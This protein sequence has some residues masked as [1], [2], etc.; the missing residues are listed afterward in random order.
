MERSSSFKH[1]SPPKTFSFGADRKE[2]LEGHVF[3]MDM[4]TDS[5]AD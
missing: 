4:D 5:D 1:A 3:E 2:F